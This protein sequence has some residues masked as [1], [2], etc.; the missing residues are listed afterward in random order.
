MPDSIKTEFD[1]PLT[2]KFEYSF[3]GDTVEASFIRLSEPSANNSMVCAQLKQAFYRAMSEAGEKS[4]EGATPQNE[5]KGVADIKPADVMSLLY[6]SNSVEVHKLLLHAKELFSS[7][8]ALVDGE[9]K[10]TKPLIDKI[11]LSDLESML[12][13]YFVNFILL[14]VL[15]ALD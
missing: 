2:K 12:G 9:Q 4:G 13:G 6:T 1:F 14:S 8:V 5:G 15:K 3:K 7:G 11:S 10:L